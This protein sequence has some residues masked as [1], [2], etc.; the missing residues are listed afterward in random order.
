MKLNNRYLAICSLYCPPQTPIADDAFTS[1][2]DELDGSKVI[3]GD[4]NA[5]HLQWGGQSVNNRG[6]QIVNILMNTNLCLLN[7]GSATRVDDR[8]GTASAIDLS[9]TSS[10]IFSDFAWE[11][12]DDS[13][14]S[15]HLP[16][17]I[18]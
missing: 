9:I 16:V 10:D 17:C 4:F 13:D 12:I 7:D 18:S 14:G 2:F 3:L 11:V 6:E 15:D 1:L 5:H 8:T